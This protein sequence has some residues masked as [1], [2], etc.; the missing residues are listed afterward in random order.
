[1]TRALTTSHTTAW[2]DGSR[3]LSYTFIGR[4]GDDGVVVLIGAISLAGCAA[5][6]VAAKPKIDS[7]SATPTHPPVLSDPRDRIGESCAVLAMVQTE[8]ENA[9]M[10]HDK[11]TLS[12]AQFAA[13]VNTAPTTL[14]ALSMLATHGLESQV[15]G[16]LEDTTITPPVVEGAA[17]NPHGEPFQ[18]DMLQAVAACSQNGTPI[19]VLEEGNG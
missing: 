6:P 19:G 3:L 7:P 14:K 4:S 9:S 13:I 15:G 2:C 12:D 5:S 17:F 16:L 8:L 1:M 10:Q 18:R 11:G